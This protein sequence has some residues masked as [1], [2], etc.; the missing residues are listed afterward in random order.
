VPLDRPRIMAILNATPDSFSDGGL[1]LDPD[2]AAEAGARFV[3]EGADVLDVGGES[4]RPGAAR[5][6]P[7]VQVERVVP[8]IE[9]LRARRETR[10][11]AITIDTTSARVASA[12]LDAGADGVND[13]SAGLEDEGLLDLVASRGAGI[14]LM[15]RL[16]TPERDSYSDEYAE[17][18]AYGDVV[19]VVRAFLRERIGAALGAG[20]AARSIAI[21]P[22]LGFGKSVKQ[23][24]ELIRRTGELAGLGHPVV[25]G[26]SRKSF[27]G[28]VSTGGGGS[29]PASRVSGTVGASV[30]HMMSGARIFRVHDVGAHAGALRAAWA[31]R[32]A[33]ASG[34]A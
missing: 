6:A 29:P 2:R 5:V 23:N 17:S 4:T 11:V 7:E 10:D 8:V 30:C 22:G 26:A 14:V 21:D 9:A 28:R 32:G 15:H 1:H 24:L 34:G 33:V 16:T 18:P 13:V 12:A 31:I 3:G 27:V 20:V 19:E 25:S